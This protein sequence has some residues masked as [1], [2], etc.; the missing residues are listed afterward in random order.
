MTEQPLSSWQRCA[1]KYIIRE[2]S[3]APMTRWYDSIS[4]WDEVARMDVKEM[5]AS[6]FSSELRAR[7]RLAGRS[8]G[9]I[10]AAG[11]Q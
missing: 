11:P 9:S 7:L 4:R 5:F 8:N 10:E 1:G 3:N 2:G 6:R